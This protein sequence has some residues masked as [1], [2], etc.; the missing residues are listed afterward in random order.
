MIL[1]VIL[2]AVILI[3]IALAGIGI[4]MLVKKDGKFEKHCSSVDS[5]GNKI[6]CVCGDDTG[7]KCEHKHQDPY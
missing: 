3:A 7:A 6:G 4:K 1:E 2:I 5:N